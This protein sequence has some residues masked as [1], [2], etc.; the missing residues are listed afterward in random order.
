MKVLIVTLYSGEAEFDACCRS[1]LDQKNVTIVHHI[2][3]NLPNREAHQR[4]Y[5]KFQ[6]DRREYDFLVK[7]D[8]DMVF[9]RDD[10]LAKMLSG[11]SPGIDALFYTVWDR[12]TQSRMWSINIFRSTC[13]FEFDN[14]DPLFTDR[15]PVHH[16][17]KKLS[18]VDEDNLVL[19]APFPSEFQ[20]FMFGVHRAFKVVQQ[21]ARIPRLE[22]SYHQMRILRNVWK[23]YNDNN[24]EMAL[25]ALCG[26]QMVFSGMMRELN[27]VSKDVFISLYRSSKIEHDSLKFFKS[28][29]KRIPIID[30]IYIFGFSRFL[31]SIFS[32][33]SRKGISVLFKMNRH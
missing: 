10:S 21:G 7:L 26:A 33:V 18:I 4:L 28:S 1:V 5:R 2:I 19:H 16:T 32:Y 13:S 11:F 6:D 27:F 20:A 17:G 15:L 3:K 25:A 29:P 8:A 12:L 9:S 22:A 14:N 24:D 23:N 30:V 31:K